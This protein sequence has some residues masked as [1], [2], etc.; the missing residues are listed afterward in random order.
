MKWAFILFLGSFLIAA[1]FVAPFL[2]Y[3]TAIEANPSPTLKVTAKTNSTPIHFDTRPAIK[4]E[5]TPQQPAVATI[6][7]EKTI[8]PQFKPFDTLD[9]ADTNSASAVLDN[10]DAQQRAKEE[11]TKNAAKLLWVKDFPYYCYTITTFANLLR[12]TASNLDDQIL[13][14][15]PSA[16]LISC[17]PQEVD[18]NAGP[19]N[20]AEI[21]FKI[22]TN[23]DFKVTIQSRDSANR[24]TLTIGCAGGYLNVDPNC[25]DPN[26]LSTSLY[27]P[28]R[29][30]IDNPVR[31]IEEAHST[32]DRSLKLIIG[33]QE[34]YL[35][36]T[37]SP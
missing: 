6:S 20:V 31:P 1:V 19:T 5:P 15:S 28:K 27:H 3:K 16:D 24:R 32:I 33:L 18:F 17:I 9:A 12:P 8:P 34:R 22:N 29:G 13:T 23:W 2:E 10:L 11:E 14:F 37:N 25:P 4:S 30:L 21:R 7:P 26:R 36:S 35:N